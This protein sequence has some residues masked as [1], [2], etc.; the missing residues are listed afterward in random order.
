MPDEGLQGLKDMKEKLVNNYGRQTM[1]PGLNNYAV[2]RKAN[3]GQKR[4]VE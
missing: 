2:I 4:I 1:F 3:K